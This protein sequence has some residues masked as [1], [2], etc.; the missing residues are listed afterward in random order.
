[1]ELSLDSG[2]INRRNRCPNCKSKYVYMQRFILDKNTAFAVI[3]IEAHRHNNEPE[4]YL[5]GI[6]GTWD[7]PNSS[8]DHITFAC[9]YG[10]VEGQE[11]YACSLV[12]VP[13]TFNSPLSGK[14][15]SRNEGLKHERINEFWH[16]VDYLIEY[17]MA[18]HDFF[19][20]PL[21]SKIKT[22]LHI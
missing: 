10:N 9:R 6:L 3:F 14:K 17:D 19:H 22:S 5:T 13:D 11:D 8:D 18:I 12:D 21:K 1:M 16:V 7:D 15:L 20:H 4:L 2:S